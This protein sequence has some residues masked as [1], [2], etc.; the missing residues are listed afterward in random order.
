VN[1]YDPLIRAALLKR[2]NRALFVV[3]LTVI[4]V[5]AAANIVVATGALQ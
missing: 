3:T 4:A 5:L 1:P 2:N